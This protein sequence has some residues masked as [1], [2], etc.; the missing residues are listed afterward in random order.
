MMGFW[1]STLRTRRI[2]HRCETCGQEVPV[3]AKSYDERGTYEGELTSYKQ[4]RGCHEIARYFF[5]RGTFSYDEGYM[6]YEL[7]DWAC[8]EGIL[9]PPVFNYTEQVQP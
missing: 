5:W 9:W 1:T 8:D 7:A 3:G 2:A 4:C 6:L